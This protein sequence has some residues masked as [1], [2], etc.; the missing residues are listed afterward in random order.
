MRDVCLMWNRISF[1]V[2]GALASFVS[3]SAN[4][5]LLLENALFNVLQQKH[6]IWK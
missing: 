6:E 3:V 2:D 1:R 4:S 5:I